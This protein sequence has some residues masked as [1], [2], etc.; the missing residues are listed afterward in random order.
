MIR[1]A[2]FVVVLAVIVV[3]GCQLFQGPAMTLEVDGVTVTCRISDSSIEGDDPLGPGPEAETLCRSRAREAVGTVLGPNP[4][5]QIESVD[6]AADGSVTVCY[7]DLGVRS[8][9]QVLP[10]MPTL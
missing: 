7:T 5:A 9:P 3:G 1:L 4:E 6:I 2:Q 10:A 8:C